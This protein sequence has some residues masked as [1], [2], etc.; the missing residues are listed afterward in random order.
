MAG[1]PFEWW[2]VLIVTLVGTALWLGATY[3]TATITPREE[4]K[5]K[6]GV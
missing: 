1:F 2:L 5:E 3:Y 4:V 6:R